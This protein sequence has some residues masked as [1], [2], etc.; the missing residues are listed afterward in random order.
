MASG[1]PFNPKAIAYP[2]PKETSSYTTADSQT[3]S[4]SVSNKAKSPPVEPSSVHSAPSLTRSP[5]GEPSSVSQHVP[6]QN[7][8]D[9]RQTQYSSASDFSDDQIARFEIRV[10]EGYNP[11]YAAWL[12]CTHPD[13][14][15]VKQHSQSS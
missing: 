11:D 15:I 10:E 3:S 12:E 13:N 14:S 6:A 7:S 4:V 2:D 5:S 8:G 9:S 1:K